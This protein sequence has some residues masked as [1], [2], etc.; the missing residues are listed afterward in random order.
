M[1][2]SLL[3]EKITKEIIFFKYH[4]SNY[5]LSLFVFYEMTIYL[6]NCLTTV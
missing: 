5:I 6:F 3:I 4:S 2:R 1:S